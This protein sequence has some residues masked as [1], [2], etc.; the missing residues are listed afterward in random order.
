MAATLSTV[1]LGADHAGFGLKE[2][3]RRH[4]EAGGY[5][6]V[7][8]GAFGVEPS[9][10]PDFIIPAVEG[11]LAH[12]SPA[13]AIVMG[14]SG[15][16]ECMAANKVKGARAALAYDEQTAILSREH[17]DA[18]V[19]CLGSRTATS[20]QALALRVVDVWLATPFSGDERHV[21]RIG[22]ISSYESS[23]D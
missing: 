20:D 4:L 3:I 2:A 12:P 6:V 7:D 10:Y 15:N 19:L 13:V 18:N 16:G 21:R 22:K 11:A 8:K 17:N 1:Y 5:T 9:D 23:R 14:G